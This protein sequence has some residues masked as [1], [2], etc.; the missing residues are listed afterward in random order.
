MQN[1]TN[2]SQFNYHCVE[3]FFNILLSSNCNT[4]LLY[5]DRVGILTFRQKVFTHAKFQSYRE[6]HAGAQNFLE[7]NPRDNIS[8]RLIFK[9]REEMH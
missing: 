1:E 8:M 4:S 7:K 2:A 3:I 6:D 5:N 9:K